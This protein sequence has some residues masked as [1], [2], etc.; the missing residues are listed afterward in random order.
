M[1]WTPLCMIIPHTGG[2]EIW[3]L[4]PFVFLWLTVTISCLL[5]NFRKKVF[6]SKLLKFL[7]TNILDE[8]LDERDGTN[9]FG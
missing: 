7:N 9:V 6:N 2:L 8:V 5:D 3:Q 4:S 1:R